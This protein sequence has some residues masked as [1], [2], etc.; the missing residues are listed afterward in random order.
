MPDRPNAGSNAGTSTTPPVQ[1]V[2]D[3]DGASL[4][5]HYDAADDA[6]LGENWQAEMAKEI[7]GGKK[8]T[9]RDNARREGADVDEALD[10]VDDEGE[11]LEGAGDEEL[12]PEGGE[13]GSGEAITRADGAVWNVEAGRWIKDNKF[14]AGD[15]PA[16]PEGTEGGGA[17]GG[18]GSE[19]EGG[20]QPKGLTLLDGDGDEVEVPAG[21]T[22]KFKAP[23]GKEYTKDLAGLVELAGRGI[24][25]HQLQQEVKEARQVRDYSAQL[26][27]TVNQY[28]A[29][30]QQY[31]AYL[32]RLFTD[33]DF[34]A[35]EVQAFSDDNTPER[36]FERA[37]EQLTRERASIAQEREQ[38]KAERAL[39]STVWPAMQGLL[40]KYP[41]I[42]PQEVLAE[43]GALVAPLKVQGRVPTAKLPDVA[44]LIESQLAPWAAQI[45]EARSEGESRT[46][47]T[48]DKA[49]K[50][51]A[52]RQERQ[53]AETRRL[54]KIATRA[55]APTG[56]TGVRAGAGGGG[57]NR[58]QRP[59]KNATEAA[60]RA[61]ERA[62]ASVNV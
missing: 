11:E 41:T 20:A 56:G 51:A 31:N 53:S 7:A 49:A 16:E 44:E 60:D 33:D 46:Q 3:T 28:E 9:I 10:G 52:A 15:P 5:E 57:G 19:G 6:S 26:E 2:H 39:T 37:Q 25:N 43:M 36:K 40:K 1:I 21:V 55:T 29:R 22:V 13:E 38:A 45:H 50:D 12:E 14:V 54:R 47:R 8:A 27:E 35:K 24:Y 62:L 18:E 42:K 30:D 58:S 34:F 32:E 4:P 23:N 17:E 48:R 61:L 59:P